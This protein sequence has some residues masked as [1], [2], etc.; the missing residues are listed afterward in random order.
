MSDQIQSV[1]S[2]AANDQGNIVFFS[3]LTSRETGLFGIDNG[4][5]TKVNDLSGKAKI[6]NLGLIAFQPSPNG[7]GIFITSGADIKQVIAPG[8]SLLGS[9]VADIKFGGLNDAGEIAFVASLTDGTKKIFRADPIRKPH[10][11]HAKIQDQV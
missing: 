1:N 3:S 9:T 6:N 2:L 5:I 10:S 8:D 4:V 7:A 11:K